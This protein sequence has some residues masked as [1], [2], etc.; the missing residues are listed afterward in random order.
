MKTETLPIINFSRLAAI[1]AGTAGFIAILITS[2]PASASSKIVG[3]RAFYELKLGD[4]DQNSFVTSVNGRSAFSI[5]RDCGGWR[6]VEDYMIQFLGDDGQ[7]DNLLSHFESWESD[8]GNMY[9]F[10]ILEESTMDGRR[11]FGGF[12][13]L[14]GDFTGRAFFSMEPDVPLVLPNETLLPIRHVHKLLESA[15]AGQKILG[16]TLFTGNEPDTALMKTNTVFGG[17]REEPS[18]GLGALADEGYYQINIA[19]FQPSAKTAEPRYEIQFA[20]QRNG[21]VREYEINYGD[22]SI[23]AKLTSAETVSAPTCS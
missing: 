21:L 12:V 9:S 19:Y 2:L 18:D 5:E 17:W 1:V 14:D 22:F 3:H 8:S 16:A 7:S 4:R 20:M 11:E 10:D 13:E 15:E 6:S 23:R